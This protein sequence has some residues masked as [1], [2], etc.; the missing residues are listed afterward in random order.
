MKSENNPSSK[1][2][3]PLAKRDHVRGAIDAPLALIE[4]GDYQ[5]PY[6]GE[7]YSIIKAIQEKLGDRLC[8]AFRNFP[9]VSSH[10][11]AEHAAEAAEAA[12]ARASSR[13]YDLLFEPARLRMQTWPNMRS[14]GS[15]FTSFT[16]KSVGACAHREDLKQ[17][18]ATASTALDA[19]INGVLYEGDRRGGCWLPD[20]PL[21]PK[22]MTTLSV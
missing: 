12:G 16:P 8:F 9:L 18:G 10:P 11:H 19:V 2:V 5:C 3:L 14:A 13:K 7:A 4:Y 1:L 17:G 15:R 6:C 20:V 22:P 21:R